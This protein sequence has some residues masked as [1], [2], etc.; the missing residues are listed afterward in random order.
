MQITSPGLLTPPFHH[1]GSLNISRKFILLIVHVIVTCL[2]FIFQMHIFTHEFAFKTVCLTFSTKKRHPRKTESR[3]QKQTLLKHISNHSNLVKIATCVL[4]EG[5]GVPGQGVLLSL[6]LLSGGI[7]AL[8]TLCGGNPGHPFLGH[9]AA[10]SGRSTESWQLDFFFLSVYP[11][12]QTQ[13]S[14]L[15]SKH[16]KLPTT[17]SG[18]N[19]APPPRQ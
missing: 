6:L 14:L 12:K 16:A 11:P 3:N 10:E 9:N 18:C 2:N 5:D 17:P 19:T 15:P 4:Q 8:S 7:S 13:W 1:M